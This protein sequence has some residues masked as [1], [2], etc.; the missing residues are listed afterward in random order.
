MSM[1]YKSIGRMPIPH[2]TWLRFKDMAYKKG[3]KMGEAAAQA[4]LEWMER[5][6]DTCD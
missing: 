4:I 1:D 2:R 5:N 3:L 6:G